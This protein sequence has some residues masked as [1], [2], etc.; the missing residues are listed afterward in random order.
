[1]DQVEVLHAIRGAPKS[2]LP[3]EK[4]TTPT[5]SYIP[6]K[7][8][9][10]QTAQPSVT[11]E[12]KVTIQPKPVIRTEP[13]KEIPEY[14]EEAPM[15]TAAI[16]ST[17]AS[18]SAQ[19]D[20]LLNNLETMTGYDIAASLQTLQDDILEKKGYSAVLRQ[21]RMG[22][23]PLKSNPNLLNASERQDLIS[24]INFWRNKLK[25]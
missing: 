18:L 4:I 1:M 24:K 17:D 9:S 14:R 5:K 20:K 8:L 21:I 11:P 15:S 19:I 23:T 25:I 3:T 13:P 10:T 22:I 2:V 16:G 6:E 12:P 7:I